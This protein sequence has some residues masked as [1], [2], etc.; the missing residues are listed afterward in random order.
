MKATTTL[1]VFPLQQV[2]GIG[3][4]LE[5]VAMAQTKYE[6]RRKDSK[7][8]QRLAAV[9]SRVFYYGQ[10]LDVLSQHHPEY[11]SLAW[12]T[13]KFLFIVSRGDRKLL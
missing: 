4:V 3:D 12:G 1:D 6:A 7:V 2:Y 8:R 13:M 11:V 5:A 9:S 10:V